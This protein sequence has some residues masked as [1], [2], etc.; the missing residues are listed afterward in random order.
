MKKNNYYV[1]NHDHSPNLPNVGILL[2]LKRIPTNQKAFT[3]IST[4]S[5]SKDSYSRSFYKMHASND[6]RP[7][8]PTSS[9]SNSLS[10]SRTPRRN[11][12]LSQKVISTHASSFV[13]RSMA[14]LFSQAKINIPE[15]STAAE[16]KDRGEKLEELYT[17][18][19]LFDSPPT[20][21]TASWMSSSRDLSTSRTPTSSHAVTRSIALPPYIDTRQTTLIENDVRFAVNTTALINSKQFDID[22]IFI[23][24]QIFLSREVEE[25]ELLSGL[26]AFLLYEDETDENVQYLLLHSTT[27]I[28]EAGPDNKQ[29]YGDRESNHGKIH[30]MRKLIT[31]LASKYGGPKEITIKNEPLMGGEIEFNKGNILWW[32]PISGGYSANTEFDFRCTEIKQFSQAIQHVFLP[33]LLFTINSYKEDQGYIECLFVP[34]EE[35]SENQKEVNLYK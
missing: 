25:I 17:A 8:S 33:K 13:H 26:Y 20:T 1:R 3:P 28:P 19:P 30:L 7:T 16:S 15:I 23:E 4:A 11:R 32:N 35:G 9:I 34:E 10:Q 2:I 14:S 5:D 27:Y 6:S 29:E 22:E 12:T 31:R 24:P 18:N 21:P